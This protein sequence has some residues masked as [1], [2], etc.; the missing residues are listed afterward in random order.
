MITIGRYAYEYI[1]MKDE[2]FVNTSFCLHC[3]PFEIRPFLPI[4]V[5]I[6]KFSTCHPLPSRT[7]EQHNIKMSLK[8]FN[9]L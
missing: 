9:L 3:R 8:K 6:V 7:G 1:T 5:S 4:L 2:I